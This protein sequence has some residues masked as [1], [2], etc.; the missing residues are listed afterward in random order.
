MQCRRCGKEL[1]NSMR[2]TFCGYENTEGNVREMTRTEKTFF[3]GV[4]IDAG[5]ADSTGST[6]RRA[7]EDTFRSQRRNYEYSTRGTYV[8][9]GGSNIFTRA[10]GSFI[11]ALL[12]G[13]RLAQIAMVLIGIAFGA[14]MFFVALPILFVLLAIGLALLALARFTR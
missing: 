1:G 2:C 12:N 9:Y 8:S 4:T 11:R 3:N 10:L 6:G 13:N 7:E 14:L 5:S